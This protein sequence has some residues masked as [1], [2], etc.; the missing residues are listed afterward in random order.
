MKR[1]ALRGFTVIAAAL[2][3]L[4]GVASSA[5]A[6]IV[7]NRTEPFETVAFATCAAGG[8]GE[9]VQLTGKQHILLTETTDPNGKLHSHFSM[10]QQNVVGVGL[11]TGDRYRYVDVRSTTVT[12]SNIS[13][14]QTWTDTIEFHL[15]GQGT[16][17]DIVAH[18]TFHFTVDANGILRV[19]VIK[20][21][22][23][24]R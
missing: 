1:A 7:A 21:F 23:E 10:N 5:S 6:G 12:I 4:V 8:G 13:P 17:S 22:F 18:V 24:C 15:I 3:L 20:G 16:G 2:G 9:E 14:P 19:E 11:T